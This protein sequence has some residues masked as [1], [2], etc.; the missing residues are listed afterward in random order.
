[1]SRQIDISGKEYK[2]L[3]FFRLIFYLETYA[4]G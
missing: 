3:I 1:M 2:S 4:M